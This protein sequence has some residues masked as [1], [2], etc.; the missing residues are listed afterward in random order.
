MLVVCFVI[1]LF[2]GNW[3]EVVCTNE[4]FSNFCDLI[5]NTKPL[6]IILSFFV[7][8]IPTTLIL[9][10]ICE[11]PKPKKGQFR[12]ILYTVIFLWIMSFAGTIVKLVAEIV[13]IFCMPIVINYFDDYMSS[14]AAIFKKYWW[15]GAVG[16]GLIL[17]FQVIS[18]ITKNIGIK[19]LN[20]NL[21]TTFILLIDYYIM[22]TLFYLYS[23]KKQKERVW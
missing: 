22:A 3:F 15:K 2:G 10:P 21:V 14:F 16:Y 6:Y 19:M 8:V 20:E 13:V 1:K 4:H 18:L 7:Y 9:L 23:I 5:E 11:T 12:V 17:A